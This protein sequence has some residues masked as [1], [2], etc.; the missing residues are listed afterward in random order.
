MERVGVV[1]GRGVL[2]ARVAVAEHHDLVEADDLGRLR[3]SSPGAARPAA[4]S[5]ARASRPW[6]GCPGSRERR[7]LEVAL[8]AAGAAHE[9]GAHALGVV[10]GQRGRALRGLV[11]GVGVDGEQAERRRA[12]QTRPR[13]RRR[14]PTRP[15]RPDGSARR[16]RAT[17]PPSSPPPC[18]A[19]LLLDRRRR[20]SLRSARRRRRTSRSSPRRPDQPSSTQAG[21]DATGHGADDVRRPARALALGLPWAD[22]GPIPRQRPP[23]RATDISP[24]IS[25][26]DVPADGTRRAGHRRHRPDADGFVHWVVA[27]LD[28]AVGDAEGASRDA[29]RPQRLRHGGWTAVPAAGAHVLVTLTR[30]EPTERRRAIAAAI[31]ARDSLGAIDGTFAVRAVQGRRSP[32]DATV[33]GCSL[34]AS[35]RRE[36]RAPTRLDGRDAEPDVHAGSRARPVAL[37]CST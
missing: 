2:H 25:W 15:I 9:H 18:A 8:L 33:Y 3:A 29:P 6:N 21:D 17:L 26:A 10:A 19:G 11:V 27:G 30:C 7:V 20:R 34:R 23:A 4:P 1:V 36:Q 37:G 14:H 31:D 32:L 13:Y 28:P 5:P 22:D 24:A 12:V 35:V 16:R